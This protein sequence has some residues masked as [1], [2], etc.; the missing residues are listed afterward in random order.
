VKNRRRNIFRATILAVAV[1]L[2]ISFTFAAISGNQ[3]AWASPGL[4]GA[5]ES[6]HAAPATSLRVSATT[7]TTAVN[8]GASIPVTISWSGGAGRTEISW[9]DIKNNSQ[10]TPTPRVPYSG[11][12]PAGTASS[13]LTAPAVPGTY[14]IRVYGAKGSPPE[15]SF[16]DLTIQVTGTT[17]PVNNAVPGNTTAITP[18]IP[19][20][21]TGI[22]ITPIPPPPPA[23]VP[24][25]I[26][27]VLQV[28]P[29]RSW[30][31][32]TDR[33]RRY[34]DDHNSKR[35][36]REERDDEEGDGDED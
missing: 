31:T 10:F 35:Y 13:T 32:S 17:A 34:S 9:P 3:A 4:N 19:G 21:A 18:P 25:I 16:Q 33:D 1:I 29:A 23:P 15:T 2:I 14:T 11:A 27:P 26:S 6:C 5:C 20:P 30:N 8:P 24:A 7:A 36:D 28:P 12:N 22:A